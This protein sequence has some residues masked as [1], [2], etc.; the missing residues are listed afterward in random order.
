M[1]VENARN[2]SRSQFAQ[3]VPFK[4]YNKYYKIHR[5]NPRLN[6]WKLGFYFNEIAETAPLLSRSCPKAIST[7]PEASLKPGTDTAGGVE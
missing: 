1:Q 5:I 7:F 2:S 4:I 6:A 3:G